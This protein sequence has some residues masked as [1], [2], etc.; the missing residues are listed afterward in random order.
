M[1][2]I[3]QNLYS[4]IFS[5]IQPVVNNK[6]ANLLQLASHYNEQNIRSSE[7]KHG[8]SFSRPWFSNMSDCLGTFNE[9]DHMYRSNRIDDDPSYSRNSAML[10]GGAREENSDCPSQSQNRR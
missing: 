10:E 8:S 5:A 9:F 7:M 3:Q 4:D 6:I 2:L 1:Q